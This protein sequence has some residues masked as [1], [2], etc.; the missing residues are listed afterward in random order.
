MAPNE[1]AFRIAGT[2]SAYD[3][4]HAAQIP[5]AVVDGMPAHRWGL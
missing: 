4:G 2:D 1:A 3:G 5:E